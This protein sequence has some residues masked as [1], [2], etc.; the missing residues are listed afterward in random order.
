MVLLLAYFNAEAVIFPLECNGYIH[1]TY[2]DI[3]IDIDISTDNSQDFN[4]WA[5]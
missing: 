4:I 1:I 5:F 2:I 3:H